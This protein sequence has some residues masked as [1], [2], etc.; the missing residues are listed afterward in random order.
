M[1]TVSVPLIPTAEHRSPSQRS[2]SH[3]TSGLPSLPLSYSLSL[4]KGFSHELHPSESQHLTFLSFSRSI[5]KHLLCGAHPLSTTV[6]VPYVVLLVR[7]YVMHTA[8]SPHD[9]GSVKPYVYCR[10]LLKHLYGSSYVD[11]HL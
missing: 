3:G 5:S 7:V 11:S 2:Q 10:G 8:P 9:I 6:F 4:S 1:T